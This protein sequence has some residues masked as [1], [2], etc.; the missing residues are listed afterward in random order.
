MGRFADR[1]Q[2]ARAAIIAS[3]GKCPE[4]NEMKNLAKYWK[5]SITYFR[6]MNQ[7]S[8]L[9]G[10]KYG[11]LSVV[12]TLKIE[13]GTHCWMLGRYHVQGDHSGCAKPPVDNDMKV[14]LILLK[15]N[16]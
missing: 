15:C 14:V 13:H 4:T 8:K 1:L 5:M 7:P 2:S 12:F 9:Q 6:I 16:F 3:S 10:I 11:I